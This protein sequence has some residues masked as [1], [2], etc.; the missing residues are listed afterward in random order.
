[1]LSGIHLA[2]SEL[3]V[4]HTTIRESFGCRFLLPEQRCHGR[5]VWVGLGIMAKIVS[6]GPSLGALKSLLWTTPMELQSLLSSVPDQFGLCICIIFLSLFYLI[7]TS[8]GMYLKETWDLGEEGT[9]ESFFKRQIYIYM[10]HIQEESR[11]G[12]ESKRKLHGNF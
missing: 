7:H 2:S 1:M 8:K 5:S 4:F 12:L 10:W 9:S 3:A 6:M 11:K